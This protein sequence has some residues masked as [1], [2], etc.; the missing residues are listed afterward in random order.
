M[1]LIGWLLSSLAFLGLLGIAGG[2]AAVIHFSRD[3][4]D[5]E[6]LAAY[7]PPVTTRLYAADGQL[8]EEYAVENR[9]FVPI[10]AI[11]DR[12]VQAFVSAEDRHF[13]DHPGIDVL[14]IARATVTNL[15]NIGSDRRL[16]G[17]STITQQVA[18]NFLL[19]NEVSFTRKIREALLALRIEQTLEKDDILEL[20]LNEIYLGRNSYGVAAAAL[21]YFNRSLPELTL[22]Q[23]AYLAGLPKAPNNYP[24]GSDAA[25]AR[26][27]YVLNRMVEDGAITAAEA[28]AARA[29]PIAVE[30]RSAAEVFTAEYFAEEVRRELVEEFP[31]EDVYRDGLAVRTSLDPA[32]QAIADRALRAGL[33]AYDRRHGWRG[34]IARLEGVA[35]DWPAALAAVPRPAGSGAW[36][37]AVVLALDGEG[38]DLGL[39]DPAADAAGPAED[40]GPESGRL[41]FAD[42]AWARPARPN[43]RV[44]AAPQRPADVL[45]VGDVILVAPV[46][47]PAGPADAFALR[48]IPEVQGAL[49]AMDPHTGRVLAMTGG[50]SYALSEFNRATQAMRQPGSAFKPFVYLSAL[51]H[52]YTPSTL[53]RDSPLTVDLGR[54]M[55]DWRP[56]NYSHDFLGLTPLR[57]GLERSRNVMTVRLLL[58]V[59]LEPVRDI[60]HDFG[61]Y[62]DMPLL[63]SMALGAGETTPLA[64]TTAYAMLANGGRRIVPTFIDRVQNRNGLTIYRHDGRPCPDCAT[65]AWSGQAAPEPPDVRETVSDPA[66]TFQLVNMMEGVVQRGTATR[67]RRLD[68]PLAG[69]TGTTNDYRDAWFLGFTPDLVVGVFIGFDNPRSLGRGE[70][71]ST[72]AAPIF[73]NFMEEAMAGREVPPFRIPPGVRMVR[74]DP[75]TGDPASP[76]GAAIW[77]AYLP[78]TE[79]TAADA[80]REDREGDIAADDPVAAPV[81]TGGLY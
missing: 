40:I 47:S 52:G 67:L 62:E 16:V 58:D 26:R 28:D 35:A 3:L 1:R 51:Q 5:H 11:P 13:Y 43:Q 6:W 42:M 68:M 61:I 24:P 15:R 29:E 56:S 41:A 9:L 60:A 65:V 4:P 34:P 2:I 12:V 36:R 21:N 79:P 7:E 10:E 78:G 64:L 17:A 19:S 8:L 59:G 33:M 30:D 77:E 44:G 31:D 81:G 80:V 57:V 53:V 70:A 63:Y 66:T 75:R 48:Q 18:K 74:V 71:G 14:G 25:L 54:G 72:A 73:G 22:A 69:K 50:Y 38:A 39:V 32:F 55:P 49:V 27:D 76:G 37:R 46:P 45:S 20:Y 23:A